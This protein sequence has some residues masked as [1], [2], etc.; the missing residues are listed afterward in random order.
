MKVLFQL[1]NKFDEII[2][3]SIILGVCLISLGVY[4][5][6]SGLNREIGRNVLICGS[7]IFYVAIIIFVFRLE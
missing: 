7:G 6:G 4:L 5:I 2:F 1:K 3:Y